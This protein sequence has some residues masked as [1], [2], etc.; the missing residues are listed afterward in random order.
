MEKS[1][2]QS[3]GWKKMI[4][5]IK[6]FKSRGKDFFKSSKK[7]I[8]ENYLKLIESPNFKELTK[9]PIKFIKIGLKI[10]V[11]IFWLC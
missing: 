4:K 2:P 9:T 3:G 6:I 10:W 8:K 7:V 1:S 11:S 5:R